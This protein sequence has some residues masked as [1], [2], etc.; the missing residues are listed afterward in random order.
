MMIK[1]LRKK[2]TELTDFEVKIVQKNAK[3]YLKKTER[4]LNKNW[5]KNIRMMLT[6]DANGFVWTLVVYNV[7]TGELYSSVSLVHEVDE[8]NK[9]IYIAKRICWSRMAKNINFI[10]AISKEKPPTPPRYINTNIRYDNTNIT[11]I[12]G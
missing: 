1:S 3:K 8:E 5:S 7:Y 10:T 4:I 6:V 2:M 12:I 9:S 11:D